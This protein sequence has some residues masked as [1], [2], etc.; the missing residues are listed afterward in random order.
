M[1]LFA[2]HRYKQPNAGLSNAGAVAD[3]GDRPVPNVSEGQGRRG[4]AIVRV[5]GRR[6]VRKR[7]C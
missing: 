3:C 2:S 5:P 6:V 4:P 7:L 1:P